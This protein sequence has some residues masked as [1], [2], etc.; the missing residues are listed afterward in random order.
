MHL[1]QR[2]SSRRSCSLTS[3]ACI[4][5]RQGHNL[6]DPVAILAVMNSPADDGV[7]CFLKSLQAVVQQ[8]NVGR[9]DPHQ[10]GVAKGL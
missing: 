7:P 4:T 10:A 8:I 5:A 3:L 1:A 6:L 2:S 9:L